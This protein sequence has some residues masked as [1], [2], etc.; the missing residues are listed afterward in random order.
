MTDLNNKDTSKKFTFMIKKW[1]K[2]TLIEQVSP[3][4]R[5]EG[6]QVDKEGAGYKRRR[7][8]IGWEV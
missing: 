3:K 1:Q 6:E 7:R 2:K 4:I 5:L 8:A